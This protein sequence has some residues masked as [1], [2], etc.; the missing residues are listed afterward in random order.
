MASKYTFHFADNTKIV[1]ERRGGESDRHIV[2]KLL[3][4]MLYFELRP[5]IEIAV[6]DNKREYRPDVV[7]FDAS[8]N[9]VVWVDCGQITLR[10]V[11]DLTRQ[12]DT[13]PIV[14][15]KPTFREMEGYAVQAMKKVKRAPRVLFL[16]FDA[17][18][19][20]SL[21]AALGHNNHLT[22]VR[23]GARLC[24]TLNGADYVT[25]VWKWDAAQSRAVPDDIPPHSSP[26]T[27]SVPL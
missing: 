20:P 26:P 27:V 4:Y 10:K 18:F 8:G 9:I 5:K 1:Q 24:V 15:I 3:G 14:I 16:G 23:N 2:L 12:L 17:D 22:W 21:I 13:A 6:S 19:V 7:A 11:D 25:T